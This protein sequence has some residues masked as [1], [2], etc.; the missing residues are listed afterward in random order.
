MTNLHQF[1][2]TLRTIIIHKTA[3]ALL[4]GSSYA[5]PAPAHAGPVYRYTI[6]VDRALSTLRV[7]ARFEEAVEHV[8]ARSRNAGEFLVT[9]QDCERDAAIAFRDRRFDLPEG[10]IAC[11]EYVVDLRAAAAAER[12]NATLADDNIVVSPA[13]W[14]WRPPLG[15]TMRL[16]ARFR[17]PEPVFVSLPWE[18][19][20][21]ERDAYVLRDSPRNARAL[22][23]FG[24]FDTAR[25]DVAGARLR[26][27][28]MQP[29]SGMAAEPL[30][31]W[32]GDAAN[33]VTLAYGRFP[34]PS[35]HV[36]VIPVGR[37]GWQSASPVPFG[38]VV[39][40]GG[41][42]IELYVDETRDIAAFRNDWT[43][44]HEFGHL[45][46]PF[47]PRTHRWLTEGFA[48]YY[49]NVLLARAGRYD[50]RRAWQE[51]YE[52]FERG[53]ASQ[54]DLSPNEAAEAGIGA[55]TMKIYW[56]G[57][58]LALMADV[59]MRRRPDGGESLDR[60]LDRLQRCC[61]PSSRAW[62][63]PELLHKLDE[64]AGAPV[65][66]P[67]YLAHADRSGFP[68]V[69]PLLARLGVRVEDGRVTLDEEAELAAIRRA[70]TAN[71]SA[72]Y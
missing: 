22:A 40:D 66:M 30:V 36:V 10:G 28:V 70:I 15:A 39:R 46:L 9:A 29:R 42:S 6:E 26:I 1:V 44:T 34:N 14:L 68:D 64:L 24:R 51:L 57:A 8:R 7:E 18:P 25:A 60:V 3:L 38:R 43:A 58:T 16:E 4:C 45:M 13:A 19:I 47:V 41:E 27:A 48:Q 35:P 37:G 21:G 23:A 32:L 5:L 49:Q 55:A 11:L 53:R 56:S 20:A 17:I 65:F 69:L 62:S 2:T 33:N 59:E 54:P 67:L 50:D 61:L 31:D 72:I 12:R 63:G 52:G 71:P